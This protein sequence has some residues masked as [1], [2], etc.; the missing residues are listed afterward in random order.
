MSR[1]LSDIIQCSGIAFGTSGARGLVKD[2]SPAVCFAFT[3]SFLNTLARRYSFSAVAI[4]IDN[5]PSSLAM[6]Q[7]CAA[8]AQAMGL[9]VHYYGV[10]PTP[11]LALQ[12]AKDQ[13]PAIMITGSHIPFDRN[14]IKFYRPDGEISKADEQS[15]LSCADTLLHTTP[16]TL[17]INNKAAQAYLQRY[18][19]ICPVN[20]LQGKHIGIYEHSS[21]GRDLYHQLLTELGAKVTRLERTDH[22]VPIDTEAVSEA[23]Q[24]KAR[25]WA[26]T[27]GFDAIFSTDGDG[28]RPLIADENGSWLRGDTV[29]LLTAK[30][31]RI[32]ALAVPVNAN[33]AVDLCGEFKQ[34]LRTRIGSPYV[35]AGMQELQTKFQ[36]VA[37]YEANGGFLIASDI[38]VNQ[39]RLCALPTRDALLPFIAIMLLAADKPISALIKALPQR[40]T[41]SER[42]QN[43]PADQSKKLLALAVAQPDQLLIMLGINHTK[44]QQLDQTDGVRLKLQNGEILHFRA[45]GNAPELRIYSEAASETAAK[46]LAH[47]GSQLN[48]S[49]T[50]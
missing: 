47:L 4:G 26:A 17:N 48:V 23:D 34:V 18:R 36:Q 35:I 8:M 43:V 41:A 7:Y 50:G 42:I 5:R 6:A 1:I 24:Q 11:A 10:L 49:G 15:I 39:Q 40:F 31:L 30:A 20:C 19:E 28:D 46:Q 27:Y 12:A 29:G 22:F 32:Q 37:G 2:F 13:I 44:T 38:E 9:A 45:S 33:S 21:A 3:Q 25:Q 16:S 14:G